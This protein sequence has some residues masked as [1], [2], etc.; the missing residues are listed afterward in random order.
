M[1]AQLSTTNVLKDPFEALRDPAEVYDDGLG[2]Q[3]ELRSNEARYNSK[4]ER[5]VYNTGYRRDLGELPDSHP[6]SA[7]VLTRYYRQNESLEF[8]EV[9]VRSPHIRRA[10]RE[11]VG[12]YNGIDLKS[13]RIIVR[14]FHRCLFYY[15]R[16]LREYA[17]RIGDGE[18]SNHVGLALRYLYR[19][20]EMEMR[21]FLIKV[22]INDAPSIDFK[23][24][25]MV[26][27]PG[28]LIYKKQGGRES[29][30]KLKS[31]KF[32]DYPLQ[33]SWNF[34]MWFIFCDGKELAHDTRYL[35]IHEY[36]GFLPIEELRCS[37]LEY[38]P[39]KVDIESRALSRGKRFVGYCGQHHCEY[40]GIAGVLT[41]RDFAETSAF[42]VVPREV[43]GRIIIDPL[44]F[45]SSC[46]DYFDASSTRRRYQ[47]DKNEHLKLSDEELK[48][49]NSQ[50]CGYSL[51]LKRWCL[52][53][54]DKI[55]DVIY[56]SNAFEHLLLDED[57]KSMIESL[58][59]IKENNPDTFDDIIKGK[60]KGLIFLL[61]GPAGCGKT[62]TAES[63]AEFAK[64]PLYI[65]TS[66]DLDVKSAALEENLLR[67]LELATSWGALVLIDEADV[68]LEERQ[69]NN[70]RR[71]SLV[72]VFLRVL[73]YFEGTMILT[74]NR[75]QT[76]DDAFKSRI[77]LSLEYPALSEKARCQLWRLFIGKALPN[78]GHEWIDESDLARLSHHSFNG[79][80]IKNV[81]R[82]ALAL[83]IGQ[84]ADLNIQHLDQAAKVI[85]GFNVKFASKR[86]SDT[87]Y[88]PHPSETEPKTA[89]IED[90]GC[91]DDDNSDDDSGNGRGRKRPRFS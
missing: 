39:N 81:V 37:P 48:I 89:G 83:S 23:S 6:E 78:R 25:W 21:S 42:E 40:K 72:S 90:D 79:R 65:L 28:A 30:L 86:P 75:V 70:L 26:F 32:N 36:E 68:F 15:E 18:A 16:E 34:E 69:V 73:E 13:R 5:V 22:K 17:N 88:R 64:R 35:H 67:E 49:C 8:S 91:S 56:D 4:G 10:L 50:A 45:A 57:K 53:D 33:C 44:R 3:C 66:G 55:A 1:D 76:F 29:I 24:L 12:E 46:P 61:H 19:T 80:E 51:K 84:E 71:N 11:V 82:T 38:H 59:V 20:L 7:L 41:E 27:R 47:I 77:H 43:T 87:V 54:L 62:L 52:F 58:I 63:L 31:I 14:D 85:A 74:T 9:D 2:R 60:G